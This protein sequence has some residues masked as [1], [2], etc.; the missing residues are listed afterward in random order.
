MV[1]ALRT[2]GLPESGCLWP[3]VFHINLNFSLPPPPPLPTYS[4][5]EMDM[6]VILKSMEIA[7]L[8]L[9][10]GIFPAGLL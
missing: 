10:L 8:R 5:A 4:C 9:T 7:V 2:W 3:S 1:V 6:E